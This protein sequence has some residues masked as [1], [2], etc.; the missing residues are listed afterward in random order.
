[1]SLLNSLQD[2]KRLGI[3]PNQRYLAKVLSNKD[4]KMLGRIRFTI[5]K[6]FDFPEE[7]S[8]WA[9]PQSNGGWDG[10]TKETGEFFVPRKDSYVD[11]LFQD[12]SLYH[13][14]WMPTYI[15]KDLQQD[16]TV[17][18]YPDR[19]I[20]QLSDGSYM[21]YD[22]KKKEI[23]MYKVGDVSLKVDGGSINVE[24]VGGG[25]SMKIDGDLTQE[26]IGNVTQNIKGKTGMTIECSAGEINLKTK[27]GSVNIFANGGN[28]N[29]MGK[30]GTGNLAGVVTAACICAFSGQPH[31]DYS[32][33]VFATTGGK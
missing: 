26:I 2:I 32:S 25:L 24:T 3:Q 4:P 10:A 20:I 1:M 33:E 5:E 6:F 27:D 23:Y 17:V 29:L 9:I 18:N 28:I 19:K 12:G 11:I 31:A 16:L 22:L 30:S 14:I 15:P 13:P 7:A 8:P 21:I